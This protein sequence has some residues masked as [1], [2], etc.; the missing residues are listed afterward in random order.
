MEVSQ[1]TGAIYRRDQEEIHRLLGDG[2]RPTFFEAAALGDA[3]SV[4]R[5]LDEDAALADA[6]SSDGF[7]AL[8]LAAFFAK[9]EIVLLLLQRGADPNALS[10]NEM[11]VRPIHSAAASGD[12]ATLQA[13]L[14]CDVD[15]NAKQERGFTALDEA[16]LN[17]N[18]EMIRALLAKGAEY[19]K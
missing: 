2:T 9:R 5:S 15:V 12:A 13:L 17:G 19:G 10:R 14:T 8:H 6:Y 1:L 7:T 4:E 16:K 11:H 3:Q 18:Q